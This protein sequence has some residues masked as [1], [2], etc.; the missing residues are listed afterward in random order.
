MAVQKMNQVWIGISALLLLLVII[1]LASVIGI[2]PVQGIISQGVR[3]PNTPLTLASEPQVYF[4]PQDA[5]ADELIKRIDMAKSTMD[6]AIYSFTLDDISAAVARA[7]ERGVTVRIVFDN[8]QSANAYSEDE[9][10]AALGVVVKRR[11]GSG[12]MHNK[13]VI[14]DGHLVGTGSFNYSDNANTKNEENLIFIEDTALAEQYTQ[15]FEEI[16]AKAS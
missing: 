16:W 5:C 10:L 6:I 1:L 14:I 3:A 2:I 12:Y 8:D 7:R 4:C 15:N 13:Y 9:K 11:N